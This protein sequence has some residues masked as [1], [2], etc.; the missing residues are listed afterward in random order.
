[1]RTRY[2]GRRHAPE[3]KTHEA[4]VSACADEKAIGAP[5]IFHLD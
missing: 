1:M 2:H 4:I 5:I 3:H